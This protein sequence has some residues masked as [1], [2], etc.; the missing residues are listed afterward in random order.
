MANPL[1]NEKEIYD[2]IKKVVA[3][4][5]P[6]V[7]GLID[8][9]WELMKHHIGND[10]YAMQM[11][12]GSR[13]VGGDPEPISVEEGEKLLRHCDGIGKFLSKLKDATSK[14]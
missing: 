12:V 7:R 3:K 5:G 10:I 4:G 11:I 9:M 6:E 14:T 8:N 1:S 2:N 13:I